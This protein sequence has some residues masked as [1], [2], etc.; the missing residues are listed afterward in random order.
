M[1]QAEPPRIILLHPLA[2]PKPAEGARC[3]GCGVCCAAEPC[4]L[5]ILLS[6]RRRGACVAL[7]WDSGQQRYVCG[8]LAQPGH[9]LPWLPATWS[10][11]LV[12]RWIAAAQGCDAGLETA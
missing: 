10:Q 6:R 7:D 5:G 2:P 11:A 4:P 1:P 8:A 3:N 12:R 9:W